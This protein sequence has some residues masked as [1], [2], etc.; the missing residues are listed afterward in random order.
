[1]I[2]G[3]VRQKADSAAQQSCP[4][5]NQLLGVRFPPPRDDQHGIGGHAGE[6]TGK[7][8]DPFMEPPDG[9]ATQDNRAIG[10]EPEALPSRG[11]VTGLEPLG[12][13]E[14]WNCEYHLARRP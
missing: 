4:L 11:P 10:R 13:D 12:I 5:G 3:Q 14:V 7:A 2:A 6:R 9:G 1:M 8:V